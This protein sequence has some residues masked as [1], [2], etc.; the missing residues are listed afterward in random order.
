MK[1]FLFFLSLFF[2]FHINTSLA[3]SW[4]SVGNDIEGYEWFYDEDSILINNVHYR[5]DR[6]NTYRQ[7]TVVF[8]KVHPDKS[9]WYRGDLLIIP[10]Q[11]KAGLVRWE[12]HKKNKEKYSYWTYEGNMEYYT[13]DTMYNDIGNSVS[14]YF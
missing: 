1:K 6:Y 7:Y 11:R 4:V 9:T 8:K 14:Q 10:E 5:N 2:L 3:A 13:T 12:K